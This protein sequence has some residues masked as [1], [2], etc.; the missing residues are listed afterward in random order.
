MIMF[1]NNDTT[2]TITR[3]YLGAMIRDDGVSLNRDAIMNYDL[4]I[5]YA[6]ASHQY[7]CV[8]ITET[9]FEAMRLL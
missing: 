7:D 5:Y 4:N 8:G 6:Y 2:I 9:I 3:I 1:N